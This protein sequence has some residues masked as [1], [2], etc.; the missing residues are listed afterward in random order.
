MSE[1]MPQIT[2]EYGY[3]LVVVAAITLQ[4]SF[5]VMSSGV[6]RYKY[7]DEAYIK[8]YLSAESD[9]LKKLTGKG[10]SR[11]CHPDAGNGRFSRHLPL[12]SW[13]AFNVAQ[14]TAGNYIEQITPILALLL[15]SGLFHPLTAAAAGAAYFFG[16]VLYTLGFKGKFGI[17]SRAPGFLICLLCQLSLTGLVALSG[18]KMTGHVSV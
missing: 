2:P 3:V 10:I 15:L 5:I 9:E 13:V 11:G 12:D 1:T 14:R 16:R 6:S 17:P 18:L 8:K 4:Y 7:M